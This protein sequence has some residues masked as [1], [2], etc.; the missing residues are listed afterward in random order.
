M[1]NNSQSE[2]YSEYSGAGTVLYETLVDESDEVIENMDR[3]FKENNEIVDNELGGTDLAAS[4]DW[5]KMGLRNWGGAFLCQ[6]GHSWSSPRPSVNVRESLRELFSDCSES[7]DALKSATSP[8]FGA[9]SRLP[10]AN[11]YRTPSSIDSN[12]QNFG[13]TVPR[14]N[15][16]CTWMWQGE[17]R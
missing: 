7:L 3:M 15:M 6:F 11:L 10:I 8:V 5:K 12:S 17:N 16:T 1:R 2:S 14:S 13:C 9:G 4:I